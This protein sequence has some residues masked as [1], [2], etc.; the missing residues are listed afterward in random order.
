MH[1]KRG[2]H[3]IEKG[4]RRKRE[5][6]REREG[7]G[8]REGGRESQ[9]LHFTFSACSWW[10]TADLQRRHA[11][12]SN[13]AQITSVPKDYMKQAARFKVVQLDYPFHFFLLVCNQGTDTNHHHH[14]QASQTHACAYVPGVQH[15]ERE[16]R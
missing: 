5:G 15:K 12:V 6:E 10:Q 3:E 2:I 9:E 8:G 14:H 16:G 13:S 7:E 1:N 4:R 11:W